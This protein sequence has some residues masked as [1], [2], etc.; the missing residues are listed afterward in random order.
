MARCGVD[1]QRPRRRSCGEG[2]D[3]QQDRNAGRKRPRP[4]TDFRKRCEHFTLLWSAPPTA[5]ITASQI[6]PAT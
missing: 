3:S 6:T 4:Y 1:T 5:K 2:D